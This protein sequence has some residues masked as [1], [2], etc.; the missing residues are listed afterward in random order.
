MDMGR[1]LSR[2][3]R[4]VGVV[5]GLV[6]ASTGG[7]PAAQ[8]IDAAPIQS[9]DEAL[10][11]TTAIRLLVS[12]MGEAESALGVAREAVENQARNILHEKLPGLKVDPKAITILYIAVNLASFQSRLGYY[13]NIAIELK[14]PSMILVGKDFPESAVTQYKVTL[15]TVWAQNIILTGEVL[16]PKA[17]KTA[18]DGLLDRFAADF[19]KANS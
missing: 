11:A 9:E 10:K 2:P 4:V 5:I 1:A 17:V 3:I 7:P 18:L 19:R 13:G 15:A 6:L 8:Q 16:A 12:E 14:R